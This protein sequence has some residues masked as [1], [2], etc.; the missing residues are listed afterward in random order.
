MR[1]DAALLADVDQMIERNASERVALAGGRRRR[2]C[3]V[4][5]GAV[6]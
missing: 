5:S 1:V 3:R 2:E 6:V 4:L